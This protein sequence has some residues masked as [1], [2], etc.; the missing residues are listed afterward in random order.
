MPSLKQ[1]LDAIHKQVKRNFTYIT[2]IDQY[3]DIEH[4]QCP[5]YAGVTPFKGDCEDFALACRALCRK[6]DIPS[7]LVFCAAHGEGHCVLEVQGWILDNNLD[8]VTEW[9]E[10]KD[11]QSISISGYEAGEEWHKIVTSVTKGV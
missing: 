1:Q 7:R 8:S 4:W 9:L 3:K 5:V 11:Y 2:D 6:A 10:M